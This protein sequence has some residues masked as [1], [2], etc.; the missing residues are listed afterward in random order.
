MLPRVDYLI[1]QIQ[2]LQN[3]TK[4]L[5]KELMDIQSKCSHEYQMVTLPNKT[6]IAVCSK[7]NNIVE[8]K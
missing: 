1:K 8:E 3:T 2:K 5:Y 6:T 4:V 7:C